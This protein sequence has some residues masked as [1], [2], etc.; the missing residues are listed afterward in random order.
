[1]NPLSCK[2]I[3]SFLNI[4][5]RLEYTSSLK[6]R[7]F[8]C[9]RGLLA[10]SQTTSLLQEHLTPHWYLSPLHVSRAVAG[11]RA[12]FLPVWT[13]FT[14]V[15][16]HNHSYTS[17]VWREVRNWI[18]RHLTIFRRP[19]RGKVRIHHILRGVHFA[20]LYVYSQENI[21]VYMSRSYNPYFTGVWTAQHSPIKYS[22]LLL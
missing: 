16:S 13:A 2:R 15:V 12:R 1:M 5:I 3:P 9:C 8:R 7:S 4:R 14:R 19:C 20:I 22:R 17:E 21:T 10:S 18:P 11:R 6:K